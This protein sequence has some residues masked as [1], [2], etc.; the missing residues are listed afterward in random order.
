M[1]IYDCFLYWD[2]DL[3]LDLRL[4]ILNDYV[5]Y[6]VIVEGNKT[7][8][9]NYKN[10]RFDIKKFQKFEKKIIYIQVKDMPEGKNP[11]IRENFQRNCIERGFK[12]IR[13]NDLI[14][15]SDLDEIPNPESILKFDTKKKYAVFRQNQYY[16]KFNL[17]AKKN[18]YWQGSRI[19]V[20]KFLKSLHKN[21]PNSNLLIGEIIKHDQ[22]TLNEIYKKSLMPE[23]L[24]FHKVS[25]QGILSWK[26][27]KSL[28]V[29]CPYS[30]EYEWKFD[31]DNSF[32]IP[33]AFVWV[34]K[35]KK[36]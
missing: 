5:D 6:F 13:D 2:E 8:Q 4:N 3:L 25:G 32:K 26:D 17:Q 31:D 22:K 34:L 14:I 19:C 33:S 12:D 20:K 29:D 23:Y 24:F 7:W 10:F 18:P 11:W 9:N 1:K 28:L 15:I 16:Y 30:L 21:F 35:P 36:K 27:Y